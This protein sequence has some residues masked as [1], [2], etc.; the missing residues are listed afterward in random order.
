MNTRVEMELAEF[1]QDI[2]RKFKKG[3]IKNFNFPRM[4]LAKEI[5]MQQAS[6]S[7]SQ[8]RVRGAAQSHNEGFSLI[9]DE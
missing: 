1:K 7:Q 2:E 5:S 6:S 3:E 9:T 8:N 4:E